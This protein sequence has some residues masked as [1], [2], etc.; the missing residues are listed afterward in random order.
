MRRRGGQ[1]RGEERAGAQLGD[2]HR[3]V[4][5]G[6]RDQLVAAAVALRRAGLGA[7]VRAGAD[8]RGR[9]GVDQRLQHGVQQPAHQLAG[10]GAAQR[11][12]QLEQG[13]LIQGHRVSPLL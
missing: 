3:Q 7:L 1:Q 11:L 5:G 2:L 8:L 9:L 6:G 13:R 12:G 4:A 10:V